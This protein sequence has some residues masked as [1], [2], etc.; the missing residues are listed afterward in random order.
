ML[1]YRYNVTLAEPHLRTANFD[2][3]HVNTWIADSLRTDMR[4]VNGFDF[5]VVYYWQ[6]RR[7][8]YPSTLPLPL[9]L[10]SP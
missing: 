9:P 4:V 2:H 3:G 8:P 7:Q 10:Y 6:V 1:L 5:P